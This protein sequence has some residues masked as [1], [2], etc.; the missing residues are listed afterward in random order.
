[1]R[2]KIACMNTDPE[3]TKDEALE[4]RRS[5]TEPQLAKPGHRDQLIENARQAGASMDEIEAA[6]AHNPDTLE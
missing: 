4:R 3:M 1:M 6:F 5:A 2:A